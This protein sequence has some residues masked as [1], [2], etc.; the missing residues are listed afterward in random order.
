MRI[1]TAWQHEDQNSVATWG[2]KQCGN[3]RIKTLWQH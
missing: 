3:L 2:S 1:K